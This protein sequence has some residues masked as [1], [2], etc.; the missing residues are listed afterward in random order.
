MVDSLYRK[1]AVI[2]HGDV[3]GST[4]LVR[5]DETVAHERVREAFRRFS[6]IIKAHR[7]VAHEV[8]GDAIVAEFAR[9]T[10]A[11]SAAI[12]FQSANASHNEALTDDLRPVL[13]VGIAIGEVVVA[14]NTLTGEG[15][16]LAQR[17][18]QIAN[19]GGIV[20]QGAA[21][22]TIP[23]RFPFAYQN[24]GEHVFKG[25][26]EPIRAYA[27]SLK[28]G[29][30]VPPSEGQ[31]NRVIAEAGLPD[32]PSIAVLPLVNLSDDPAQEYFTDGITE[33][34]IMELSRFRELFVIARN[35]SFVFKKEA[36]DAITIGRKLGVLFILEGSMRKSGNRIRVTVQL[37]DAQNGGHLWAERYDRELEEIFAVQDEIVLTIVSTLARRLK[38]AS[39]DRAKWK[40]I[41]NLQAYDY[42]LRAQSILS[43]SKEHNQQS[44]EMYELAIAKDS[45]CARAMTNLA[46]THFFDWSNGWSD[47]PDRSFQTGLELA[48]KALSLDDTDARA[49][50]HMGVFRLYRKEHDEALRQY[51]RS[52][53]INPNDP[54]ARIALSWALSYMGRGEE[55]IEQCQRAIRLNPYYPAWYAWAQGHA[56]YVSRIYHKVIAPVQEAISRNPTFIPPYRLLAAAYAQL[57][58][59]EKA[60]AMAAKILASNPKY[61]LRDEHK[62]PFKHSDDL[63][64]WLDGLRKA[65]LPE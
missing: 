27:V 15:V 25:F 42:V 7:G 30:K 57:G 62:R 50:W 2:L 34:I 47:A 41:D 38:I 46:M 3:V 64:H 5:L 19:P 6:E 23:K 29:A 44:R 17:L 61:C 43:D 14:D 59:A 63:E 10:D 20:I 1:L 4:T 36:V 33:D 22:E 54:D 9:V 56:H 21:H 11:V 32:R 58:E 24:L 51:H 18:E 45:E 52:I 12:T 55:A 28:A 40:S 65:G 26:C 37:V 60:H 16:V 35:S 48:V 31:A 53:S 13:R 49:H 8:R 39:E